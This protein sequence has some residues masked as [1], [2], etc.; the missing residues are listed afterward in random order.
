MSAQRI[1]VLKIVLQIPCRNLCTVFRLDIL[2][3]GT[4]GTVNLL[5]ICIDNQAFAELLRFLDR[6]SLT[7]LYRRCSGFCRC[8]GR[9]FLRHDCAHRLRGKCRF[10]FRCGCRLGCRGVRYLG[11]LRLCRLH[12][13]DLRQGAFHPHRSSPSHPFTTEYDTIIHKKFAFVTRCAEY[14]HIPYDLLKIYHLCTAF[15][16]LT[17][18][19]RYK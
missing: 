2:G 7:F 13:R 15:L 8:G 6:G 11:C 1:S 12:R 14:S 18:V 4:I 3:K 19:V 17:R 5:R 16:Y 10:C 9:C